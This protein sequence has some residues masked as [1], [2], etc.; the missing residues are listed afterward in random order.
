MRTLDH[1][2]NRRGGLVTRA[3]FRQ[4]LVPTIVATR[5]LIGLTV[6]ADGRSFA[7]CAAQDDRTR[8]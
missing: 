7:V 1:T 5:R 4:K 3:F 6:T 2:N 8:K